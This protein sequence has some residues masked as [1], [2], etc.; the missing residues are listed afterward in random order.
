M[1]LFRASCLCLLLA[2]GTALA[3]EPLT[4]E[5]LASIRSVDEVSVSPAGD[6][7]AFPRQP[8]G[9]GTRN[10]PRFD[11]RQRRQRPPSHSQPNTGTLS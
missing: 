1:K 2:L 11:A 9:P 4:F 10:A 7:V 8:Q 5:Q 6:R 3:A